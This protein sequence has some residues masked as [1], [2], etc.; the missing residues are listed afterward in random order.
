M[1]FFAHNWGNSIFVSIHVSGNTTLHKY[2]KRAIN[3]LQYRRTR[4]RLV[5]CFELGYCWFYSPLCLHDNSKKANKWKNRQYGLWTLAYKLMTHTLISLLSIL[6]GIIG[7]NGAG[8][9]FK[10]YS[11]GLTGNTIAG[12]FGSILLIKTFGRFGLDPKFILQTGTVDYLLLISNFFVSVLGGA[13]AL[14]VIFKLKNILNR[15]KK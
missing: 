11:F 1:F 15:K 2:D 5:R 10:K 8:Y 9:F 12:V 6:M 3:N 13:I 14:L 4:V 7:A